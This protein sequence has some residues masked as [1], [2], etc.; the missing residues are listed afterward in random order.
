MSNISMRKRIDN[1]FQLFS[2][3]TLRNLQTFT[4]FP[5]TQGLLSYSLGFLNDHR[6]HR[7]FAQTVPFT[8]GIYQVGLYLL[9]YDTVIENKSLS[10]MNNFL[11]EFPSA[12]QHPI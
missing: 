7:R 1:L 5:I 12:M 3:Q 11:P 8:P 10:A 4:N 6:Q 9:G 2:N